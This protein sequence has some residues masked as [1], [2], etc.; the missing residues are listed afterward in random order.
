MSGS[1][2]L[3]T[4]YIGLAGNRYPNLFNLKYL[5]NFDRKCRVVVIELDFA[6]H[7]LARTPYHTAHELEAHFATRKQKHRTGRKTIYLME[8]LQYDFIEAIASFFQL[9]PFIFGTQIRSQLWENTPRENNNTPNLLSS[10]V[11]DGM[12]TLSYFEPFELETEFRY[13]DMH[14][15]GRHCT[16]SKLRMF[17]AMRFAHRRASFW[18]CQ[19]AEEGWDGT[20]S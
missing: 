9:S 1:G 19:N 11:I 6:G 3:E 5:Q 2:S 15:V 13:E 16:S 10:R 12:F 4:G 14:N 18:S 7:I 8:D 20:S 17:K